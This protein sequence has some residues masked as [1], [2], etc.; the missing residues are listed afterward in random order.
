MS[1]EKTLFNRDIDNE[2]KEKQIHSVAE[3]K[4]SDFVDFSSAFDVDDDND[5]ISEEFEEEYEDY[6]R[7]PIFFKGLSF[8]KTKRSHKD[9]SAEDDVVEEVKET[10]SP[11]KDKTQEN[12]DNSV[13]DKEK[14]TEI[15]MEET[16]TEKIA[17]ENPSE[18]EE[19]EEAKK[20]TL[21][22]RKKGK[23]KN[24]SKKENLPV[25]EEIEKPSPQDAVSPD[26]SSNDAEHNEEI[27]K[28][29]KT[30]KEKN[31]NDVSPFSEKEPEILLEEET[32]I[33]EIKEEQP[34]E[35]TVVEITE[36]TEEFVESKE[37][38]V[39]ILDD[40]EE[41]DKIE[42]EFL[43]VGDFQEEIDGIVGKTVKN[44]T[45]EEPSVEEQE[46]GKRSF[47]GFD[48]LKRRQNKSKL[49]TEEIVEESTEKAEE[50]VIEMLPSF[51]ESIQK[52]EESE[53]TEE[54]VE[55]VDESEPVGNTVETVE[56]ETVKEEISFIPPFEAAV[57]ENTVENPDE[58]LE[59]K[60]KKKEE[61]V[62][63]AE[64]STD[65]QSKESP[66]VVMTVKDHVTFILIIL[67]LILTIVFIVVKFIP[68]GN[69]GAQDS[70][71]VV[72]TQENVSAI[73][74]SRE[75]ALGHY[76]QSDIDDVFYVYSS[77]YK[78]SFYQCNGKKMKSIEIAG[79][80]NPVVEMG[81]EKISV[82]VDYVEVDGKLFGTGVFLKNDNQGNSFNNM[83]VFKLVNLPKGYEEDGK[84]LLLATNNSEALSKRCSMWNDS[85]VVDLS[86][87]KTT[88]FLTSDNSVYSAGY[89]LLTD[90][91]YASTNGEIPF[92]STRDYDATTNKRDIYLK[93]KGKETRFAT[94]VA[95]SFVYT[96]DGA[97]SYLKVTDNGFNVVRKEN[98]KENVIFSLDNDTSY[99]YHN[100][101]L[102]DKYNG[103]LYNV[104]TGEKIVVTGYGM[105]N[106]EMMTV[107]P[108]GKYLVVVG[109]VNSAIDYQVHIFD[110]KTGNCAKY[111]DDN[112]SQH[113]N[114]S[115]VNDTTII[116][117]IVEPKQG[118]EYVILDVSKAF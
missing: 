4:N 19:K 106:P 13:A 82:K 43:L 28:E 6:R 79:T 1:D 48:F 116:Y 111:V 46:T 23:K 69:S 105:S 27:A 25:K 9:L 63:V 67:A 34:N 53:Q 33:E 11:V 83:V 22:K 20:E 108:D 114:L 98:G 92:F 10:A 78:P 109:A 96:D 81:N 80:V 88:R 38:I 16:A 118:Y 42:T 8:L 55:T 112:F 100:E 110:L 91:G 17:E 31:L 97:V 74:L 40:D 94:D 113:K 65:E 68:L 90:E 3:E 5:V 86:T 87:G 18:K 45:N 101:Y 70:D 56:E 47:A 39:I 102:L 36:K 41:D 21:P 50:S 2:N 77:E 73:Q 26:D 99:L 62:K 29:Q 104:K 24:K 93:I 58:K 32:Q 75:S 14:E 103:N 85:Y 57:E 52:I 12:I 60:D 59:T 30:E 72:Q 49:Q 89:S 54:V 35:E 84:A 76:V 95:G 44:E 15:S 51:E 7:A 115:F 117:S 61:K 64:E 66:A 71:A 37:E 107:S